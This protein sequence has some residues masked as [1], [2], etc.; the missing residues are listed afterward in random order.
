MAYSK[1]KNLMHQEQNMM[2]KTSLYFKNQ[3]FNLMAFYL[4]V[5]RG[6]ADFKHVVIHHIR[7]NLE[8]SL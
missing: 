3:S 7:E 1:S 4:F 5:G 8:Y 2:N 6:D